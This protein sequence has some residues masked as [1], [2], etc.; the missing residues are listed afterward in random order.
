MDMFE[1]LKQH[2]RRLKYETYT[3]YLV[4][5]DTRT[6]WYARL[7]IAVVVGYVFSPIDL[8][9]DFIPVLGYLDDL[10]LIPLG[11]ALV[12]RLIPAELLAEHRERAQTLIAQGKP[13]NRA[14]A[15]VIVGIWLVAAGWI[16][17]LLYRSIKY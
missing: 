3:L 9:P 1:K 17:I 13:I 4:A 14:A 7:L 11:V 12:L 5:R 2:G 15:F 16:G 8:I 6:P 10:V